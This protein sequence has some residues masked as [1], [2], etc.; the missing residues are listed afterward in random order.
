MADDPLS[1]ATL[2]KAQG[3][4]LTALTT[5]GI[6]VELAAEML[7]LDPV[8][9]KKIAD[10]LAASTFTTTPPPSNGAVPPAKTPPPA[11][12]SNGTRRGA[13]GDPAVAASGGAGSRAGGAS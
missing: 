1:R 11:P 4:A 7:D 5:S 12:A 9:A 6:S 3:D 13:S 10:N 2:A 8:L